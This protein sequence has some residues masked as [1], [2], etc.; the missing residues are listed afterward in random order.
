MR[1]NHYQDWIVRTQNVWSVSYHGEA[2]AP[3][4]MEIPL[5]WV[6]LAGVKIIG[7][8]VYLNQGKVEGIT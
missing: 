3:S 6:L 4:Q 5:G 2:K 8:R 1:H 7:K